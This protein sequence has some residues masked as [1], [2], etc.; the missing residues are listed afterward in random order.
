MKLSSEELEFV[1][2]SAR[3]VMHGM[4]MRGNVSFTKDTMRLACESAYHMAVEMLEARRGFVDSCELVNTEAL[5]PVVVKE[6]V[7]VIEPEEAKEVIVKETKNTKK[8]APVK[9]KSRKKKSKKQAVATKVT[10]GVKT[11]GRPKKIDGLVIN[12]L[13]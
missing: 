11:K 8:S 9:T 1:D 4:V 3:S 12:P 5:A 6:T 2:K 10:K 7:G 13:G